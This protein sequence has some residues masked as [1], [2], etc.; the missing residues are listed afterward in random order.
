MHPPHEF[1]RLNCLNPFNGLVDKTTIVKLI[2]PI[3]DNGHHCS[4]FIFL[5]LFIQHLLSALV[6]NK[7][8]LMRYLINT[9]Q[10]KAINDLNNNQFQEF[11]GKKTKKNEKKI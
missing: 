4:N 8:A 3:S 7:Y 1:N 9:L 10:K 6:T 5:F 11:K 2:V